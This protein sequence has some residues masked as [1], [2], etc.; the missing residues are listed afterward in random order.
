LRRGG[1]LAWAGVCGLLALAACEHPAA[2]PERV[3]FEILTA[4]DLPLMYDSN[5]HVHHAYSTELSSQGVGS[6]FDRLLARGI[7]LEEAWFEDK[8]SCMKNNKKVRQPPILVIRL[9]N[10]SHM[11]F[12]GFSPLSYIPAFEKCPEGAPL[13]HYIFR[14]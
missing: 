10:S 13:R 4:A 11:E 1:T 7:P 8:D 12:E 2:P 14:K 3:R 5:F 6:I 9:G